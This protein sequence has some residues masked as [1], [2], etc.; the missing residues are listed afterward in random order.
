MVSVNGFFVFFENSFSN[1]LYSR[2]NYF[3]I[4]Y[5]VSFYNVCIRFLHETIRNKTF[6]SVHSLDEVL[7]NLRTWHTTLYTLSFF[8]QSYFYVSNLSNIVILL[9]EA[10][11][12]LINGEDTAFYF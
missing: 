8:T 1:C 10:V 12:T 3:F 9:K 2:Y 5:L 11:P 7:P 4:Q 6:P